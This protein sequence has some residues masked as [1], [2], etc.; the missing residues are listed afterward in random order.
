M[1]LRTS[2]HSE[3]WNH[4]GPLRAETKGGRREVCSDVRHGLLASER[5]RERTLELSARPCCGSKIPER[6]PQILVTLR[7]PPILAATWSQV[8]ISAGTLH[9]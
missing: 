8:P 6:R 2:A 4:S 7:H 5:V 1:L 3:R 9:V